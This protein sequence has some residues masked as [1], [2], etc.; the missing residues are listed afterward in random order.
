[1]SLLCH[2]KLA[3]EIASVGD[4]SS[5]LD[6]Y[7]LSASILTRIDCLFLGCNT[8]ICSKVKWDKQGAKNPQIPAS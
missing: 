5:R 7:A 6:M 1:M 4:F 3:I 8:I 2:E